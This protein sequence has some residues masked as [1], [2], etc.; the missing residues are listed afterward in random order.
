MLCQIPRQRRLII[1]PHIQDQ[2]L[3]LYGINIPNDLLLPLHSLIPL[4]L[5]EEKSHTSI[6]RPLC[7]KR[8]AKHNGVPG[9]E[10]M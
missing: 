10:S 2:L 8:P 6:E 5:D 7:G 4:P 9:E 1:P 3:D